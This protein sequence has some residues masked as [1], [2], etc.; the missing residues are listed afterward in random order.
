MSRSF[1]LAWAMALAA[2]LAWGQSAAPERP[3]VISGAAIA[4]PPKTGARSAAKPAAPAIKAAL[5][6]IPPGAGYRFGPQPAWVKPVPASSTAPAL[7]EA[8]AAASGSRALRQLL[9][10]VQILQTAKPGPQSSAYFVRVQTMA[11][12]ASTLREV[13][14]PQISFNP[15]Y[16][17]LII[18][19]VA[20][21]RDGQRSERL[22]SSRVEL[23]RR[24]H[25]LERQMIDGVRTA[26]VVINDVRVGDVVEA[27]Y[28]VEGDNPI[29]ENRLAAGAQLADDVPID[30]LHW[31]LEAPL[32]RKIAVKA[33]ASD[34]VPERFEEGG[35]QVL[36]VLRERVAPV[37]GESNTPPWFKVYPAL[38][39][40]DYT[41][42][43]E[44]DAWAQRL[45]APEKPHASVLAQAEAIK[46]EVAR[47]G[48]SLQDQVAAALRFVQDE[49]RYFSVSLGESSHRPKPA[50]QT[51]AERLG[52]CKDKT[53]LLNAL[54]T[55]LGVEAKPALVSF[56]RNRGVA[57]YPP[58]HAEFDHVISRVRV[59]DAVYFLDSTMNGQGYS[60]A[61]RGYYPYGLALVVGEGAA[62]LQSAMPPASALD[63]IRY[64]QDWDLGDLT[65]LPQLRVSFQ[66]EG[67]AAERWRGHAAQAGVERV[68]EYFSGLYVK[69]LPGLVGTA[70]PEWR[71]DREA[72]RIELVLR[73][74]H[75]QLGRYG[76][77]ALELDLPTPELADVLMLPSEGRRRMPYMLDAPRQFELRTTIHGPRPLT[78]QTPA[79]QQVGDKHFSFLHRAEVVKGD[80]VFTSRFERRSDEV[81]PADIDGYRERISRART[82]SG[83]NVRLALVDRKGLEPE[84][85]AIDKRLAKFRRGPKGDGLWDVLV[86]NEV[87]RSYDSLLLER[88]G[89]QG[90]LRPRVL[91][92]RAKASN[93]L[94]DF[95]AG[96]AD[97]DAALPRTEP[98]TPA[99]PPSRG[100]GLNAEDLA[101]AH[102]AR[103]VALA[104]LGRMQDAQAAFQAQLAASGA[105]SPSSWLGVT[106]FM[107]GDFQASESALR[108]T[109]NNA[110]G[111]DR[112]FTLI[113]LYLASERQQPG[114]GKQ[115]LRDEAERADASQWSGALMRHLAGLIDREALLQMARAKPEMERLRLAEAYFYI[116]QQALVAGQRADAQPWFER[117]VATQ[118]VPYRELSLARWELRR[119]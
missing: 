75:P 90:P 94:G 60:L 50:S 12:D 109:L 96:L 81:L 20:V 29:F 49:V 53:Q 48:G 85:E 1:V 69:A 52:D 38:A 44:V 72:N 57:N 105:G 5:P 27:S 107:L 22:A 98:T 87:L 77:A 100:A 18:H 51:L 103:G 93:L 39:V 37:Q 55:A 16:Q 70:A 40:T 15:A 31:R 92:E 74:E 82:V 66:A 43:D 11:L 64:Q 99:T 76:R 2:S 78:S 104:G 67:L 62:G 95:A 108:E 83:Q 115:A 59:G 30:R 89:P 25:N 79:P 54:L 114:R 33:L 45:F 110:S 35:R 84:Y 10:D 119:R 111:E 80:A 73:F 91:I 8:R 106:H 113:W 13:S 116:G 24:E 3:P 6:A 7:T 63:G 58:S 86:A 68:S 117:S 9:V 71:D 4:Q 41:G 34:L 101:A 23:M 97:A 28:T 47:K 65:R 21:V 19:S 112:S 26:L 32:E 46:A 14:E 17:Q 88:I 61:T 42:W 118:A 102:E 56:R 36:R